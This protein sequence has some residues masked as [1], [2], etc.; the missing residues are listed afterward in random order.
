MEENKNCCP[1]LGGELKSKHDL[2]QK[3][4]SSFIQNGIGKASFS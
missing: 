2:F 4:A 1:S 3:D